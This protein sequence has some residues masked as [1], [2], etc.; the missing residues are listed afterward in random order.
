VSSQDETSQ[1]K[2]FFRQFIDDFYHVGALAPSSAALARAGAAY[3]ARK[4][5][6]ARVLEAGAGTGAF[7]REIVPLLTAGDRFDVVEINSRLMGYLQA[8]FRSEAQFQ[9]RP[10]VTI[11]LINGDIRSL[12]P[13][14]AYDYIIFALPLTNFPPAMVEEILSLMVACLKPG[15]VFSYVKYIFIGRLKYL[16]GSRQVRQEMETNQAIIERFS[17]QYQIEQRAVWWNA[18]PAWVYYWQKPE[19]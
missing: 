3:L 7:T 15:G 13:A 1:Q 19:R 8:R 2:L 16:F 12:R 11:N 14:A 17:K 5:G 10:G 6:P 18:P 9:P 4:P